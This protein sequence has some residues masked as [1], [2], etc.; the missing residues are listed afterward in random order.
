MAEDAENSNL[1]REPV[2]SQETR[3]WVEDI[4][5]RAR[6][7]PEASRRVLRGI[8]EFNHYDLEVYRPILSVHIRELR[9]S[10]GNPEAFIKGVLGLSA[11]FFVAGYKEGQAKEKGAQDIK[12]LISK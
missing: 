9:N 2:S 8:E 12:N 7:D 10:S 3:N 5:A 1:P 6:G 11:V 4:F